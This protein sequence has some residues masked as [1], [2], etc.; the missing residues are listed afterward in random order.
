M[1]KIT[2]IKKQYPELNISIIDLFLKMDST[3]TNKYLPLMCKLLSSRFQVNKL[4]NK[5]DEETE[6]NHIKERVSIMGLNYDGMSNNELYS[7]YCLADYFNHEDMKLLSSFQ[8]YNERGLIQNKD[9][10]SYQNFE[11]IMASVGLASLKEDEKELRSQIIREHDDETWL[12]L[13]PLT[14]GASSKYGAAT[15]W[16][17]TY[18]NDK[19]YFERYWKRGILVYFINKIT[20][21]KFALFK[22]LDGDK[23]LSFWNAADQRVDFLE[24]DIDDYMFPIIKQILKSE[25]TNRDLSSTKIRAQV[26]M[27]CGLYEKKLLREDDRYEEVVNRPMMEE[28]GIPMMEEAVP[29]INFETGERER[30]VEPRV[31]QLRPLGR[32]IREEMNNIME[33]IGEDMTEETISPLRRRISNLRESMGIRLQNIEIGGAHQVGEEIGYEENCTQSPE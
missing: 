12:A 29:D 7:Y 25:E 13:R 16:C 4:W 6:M 15:K 32:E 18:Q 10:T 17:T 2:E 20:G 5:R 8:K 14:F 3:K 33:E 31:V 22:A 19:Q 27:E 23:E 30:Y 26:S 9:V 28:V 21:L 1:S 24:L 11:Q